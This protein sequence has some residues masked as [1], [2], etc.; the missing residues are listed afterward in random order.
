[1]T[2][3]SHL[4]DSQR[5]VLFQAR[6]PDQGMVW[7]LC[8]CTCVCGCA[9]VC[10]YVRESLFGLCLSVIKEKQDCMGKAACVRCVCVL[11]N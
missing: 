3:W 7:S 11:S 5:D 9:C 6:A 1:M 8:V 10:V 4:C 2:G